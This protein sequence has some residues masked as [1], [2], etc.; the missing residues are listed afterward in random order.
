METRK[1]QNLRVETSLLGFG[2]MRFPETDGKIDFEASVKLIDAAM[3]SGVN[4]Y[5][6]AYVYHNGQSE[7]FFRDG[8]IRRYPRD[9]FL[10]ADKLPPWECHETADFERLLNIQLE[11][12]GTE[13][14]DFYL[15]H[16]ISYPDW[17]R[18]KNLGIQD[19]L[20]QKRA[21]GKIR[22]IGFSSH[23]NPEGFAKIVN[24]WEAW[25]FAQL[26][27]NYYD[28][29]VLESEKSYQFLQEKGLPLIV[30][31]PIR[32]GNLANLKPEIARIFTDA[33]PA[34]STASYAMRWVGALPNVA[35]VLSGMNT[36][37]QIKDNAIQFSPLVPLDPKEQALIDRA[38][39]A[40]HQL[41]LIPCTGCNY[42][43]D[44]PSELNIAFLL[45]CMNSYVKFDSTNYLTW[46]YL[47][48]SPSKKT[49]AD[50][51]QCGQ[52]AGICPQHIDIP[53][54]LR[55]I[56]ELALEFQSQE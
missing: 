43:V 39:D 51:V 33:N 37:E 12:L 38:L 42:C 17:E 44:C 24:D 3:E 4:Y 19:W 46:R 40:L 28:W 50:C 36:V 16:S 13:T 11:R 6:T 9:R 8:L 52:C 54:E 27:V 35:T 45:G 1:L 56:H 15:V 29:T 14:I 30:M 5:D 22:F 26:Q 47:Y 23:D 55:K 49:Y 48:D 10:I 25:Q 20:L 31:E 53:E 7:T 21:E 32:G 18:M 2:G 41:T 34:K